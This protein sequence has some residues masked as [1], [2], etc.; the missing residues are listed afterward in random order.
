MITIANYDDTCWVDNFHI[1]FSAADG[2][3]KKQ[4]EIISVEGSMYLPDSTYIKF[5]KNVHIERNQ[6]IFGNK[7]A[8]K[9]PKT[10]VV[11]N[12]VF[13]SNLALVNKYIK[14][15]PIFSELII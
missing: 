15:N 14:L 11:G 8:R 13:V 9:I 5:L 2:A 6:I 10:C 3:R 7:S 12:C 4:S 1:L